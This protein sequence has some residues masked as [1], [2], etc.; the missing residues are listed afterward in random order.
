MDNLRQH[1]LDYIAE[2]VTHHNGRVAPRYRKPE[3]YAKLNLP[4]AAAGYV[5]L[6]QLNWDRVWV[7]SDLHFHHKNILTYADRPFANTEE[8]AETLVANF[9]ELVGPNDHSMWVGDVTFAR[10]D[11]MMNDI[12][13]QMNGYK[14]LI[15]GNHDFDRGNKLR[16]L[17]FN[18]THLCYSTRQDGVGMVFTHFPVDNM[19]D[20]TI[21]IHGHQ[22]IGG[23]EH[24]ANTSV[25]H[26]NVNCEY[27]DYK[28]VQLSALAQLSKQRLISCETE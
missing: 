24:W 5:E 18:E 9:N 14:I 26:I 12:L 21:N 23:F 28:P 6:T 2:K 15:I 16:A 3:Q 27:H 7:W 20:D 19:P 25:R 1:Y 10:W 22:H 8:M 11:G 4:K 13:K 17:N